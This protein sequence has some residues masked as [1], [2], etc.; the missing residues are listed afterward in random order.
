MLLCWCRHPQD[1]LFF[2]GENIKTPTV[3]NERTIALPKYL[4]GE[5]LF[6]VSAAIFVRDSAARILPY[7]ELSGL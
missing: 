4:V 7:V 1:G 2:V 5:R 3:H 6:V